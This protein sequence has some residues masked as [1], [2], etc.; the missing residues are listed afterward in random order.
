MWA[1][2]TLQKIIDSKMTDEIV[3]CLFLRWIQY[4]IDRFAVRILFK[5]FYYFVQCVLTHKSQMQKRYSL[6]CLLLLTGNI[7]C[8]C[9]LRRRTNSASFLRS[10]T[11]DLWVNGAW[12]AVMQFSVQF[13]ENVSCGNNVVSIY[14]D[15]WLSQCHIMDHI[16][17]LCL[18]SKYLHV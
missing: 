16:P 3:R 7:S 9:T 17:I 10:V 2:K 13:R 5:H 1:I 6:S 11:H 18:W 14:S 8:E 4:F 12:Y 15:G